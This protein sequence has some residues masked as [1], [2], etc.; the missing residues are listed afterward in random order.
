MKFGQ[1]EIIRWH[2]DTTPE[3]SIRAVLEKIDLGDTLGIDEIWLGEHHFSRHGLVSGVFSL[4]RPTSARDEDMAQ[5]VPSRPACADGVHR[6]RGAANP[7][8]PP[9]V[10]RPLEAP[11]VA[12]RGRVGVKQRERLL[13]PVSELAARDGLELPEELD[14]FF[15]TPARR[16]GP[17]EFGTRVQRPRGVGPELG[18]A[19]LDQTRVELHGVLEATERR[20]RGGDEQSARQSGRTALAELFAEELAGALDVSPRGLVLAQGQEALADRLPQLWPRRAVRPRSDRR[21]APT[22]PRAPRARSRRCPP[23]RARRPRAG[24]RS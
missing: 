14:R 9:G 10:P 21:A 12:Q 3:Q 5:G 7:R 24:R 22:R 2:P 1:F 18:L 8:L 17:S 23:P 11:E 4:L 15:E 20:P 6:A 13:V 19:L 16:A